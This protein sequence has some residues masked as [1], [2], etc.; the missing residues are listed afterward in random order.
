[1][2]E[3]LS[4][5]DLL[6]L[7]RTVFSPRATDK[8][9]AILVD[10][11]DEKN[12]DQ[13]AWLARRIFARQ[14]WQILDQ[15]R[16]E[17]GLQSVRLLYYPNVHSN[18]AE[19]PEFCFESDLDPADLTAEFL[20]TQHPPQNFTEQLA[21]QQLILAPTQFSTTAPLE[22]LV[23]QYHFRAATMPGFST[24]MMPALRLDWQEINRRVDRIKQL[25]D[26][27]EWAKIGFI[28]DRKEHLDLLLDLRFRSA[29]ASGGLF[30]EPGTAGNLP[31]GESYIFPYEGEKG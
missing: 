15:Q 12:L 7:I 14:W 22:L 1:M 17:L 11:P 27:A 24:A 16:A 25:L 28:V 9:L 29:H 21:Q 6:Q 20:M 30:P 10:V 19:L 2:Q 31:S 3:N 5:Q 23:R 4:A 18:N 13:P 8:Q 26:Q